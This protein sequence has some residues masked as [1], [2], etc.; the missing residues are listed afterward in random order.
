MIPWLMIR[1]GLWEHQDTSDTW[2]G[3]LSEHGKT[4]IGKGI[5][6]Y[7]ST[8]AVIEG[9]VMERADQKGN[10]VF[11]GHGTIKWNDGTAYEGNLVNSMIEGKGTLVGTGRTYTGEF[12]NAQKHGEGVDIT[13]EPP[14]EFKGKFVRGFP[15]VGTLKTKDGEEYKVEFDGKTDFL[16][17]PTFYWAIETTPPK[18]NVRISTLSPTSEEFRLA[19][20]LFNKS[21]IQHHTVIGVQRC[22]NTGLRY[23]YEGQKKCMQMTFGEQWNVKTMESWAFHSPGVASDFEGVPGGQILY[24]GFLPSLSKKDR[25]KYGEG[26]YFA[27]EASTAGYFALARHHNT[28]CMFLCRILLG[29]TVQGSD[30]CSVLPL[31]PKGYHGQRCDTFVDNESRP[32]ICVVQQK[33]QAIPCFV[34]TYQ[35]KDGSVYRPNVNG[36]I[37]GPALGMGRGLMPGAAPAA[38]LGSMPSAAPAAPAAGRG[39]MP[40]AAPAAPPA[41]RRSA[42]KRARK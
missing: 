23:L 17:Y 37:P 30:G 31:D 41:G 6:T 7:K 16:D 21:M 10:F 19:A 20:G 40:S 9:T 35:K 8:G 26:V 38:G 11:S 34:I 3:K 12:S 32:E 25:Q 24:H 27:K 33:A 28:F 5:Y 36:F 1:I 22:E 4:P 42:E 13:V 14:R 39:L 2:Q 15:T 29:R 18:H